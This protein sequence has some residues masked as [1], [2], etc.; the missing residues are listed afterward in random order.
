MRTID[1][2]EAHEWQ[3]VLDRCPSYDFYH[4]AA[5]HAIEAHA[6]GYRAVLFVYEEAETLVALPL[7]LRPLARLDGL[8][9]TLDGYYDA[10]SVY[11]YPGPVT[12]RAW[13]DQEFFER[14]GRALRRQFNE[15]RIIAVFSRLHPI[16]QNDAGLRIGEV[17]PLGETVSINL[18][19]P[20][21]EQ[22]RLFRKSHRYEIR[23]A[24][25]EN[26]AVVHDVE[27]AYYHDLWR[28]TLIRCSA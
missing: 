28:S 7:I 14:F 22:F 5:Y 2:T 25:A 17:I 26:I 1:C 23:K 13:D 12:N 18:T 27:W 10:T 19:L 15:M 24:R 16:L 20:V 6:D 8:T 9:E 4:M 3:A 21:D 11:G